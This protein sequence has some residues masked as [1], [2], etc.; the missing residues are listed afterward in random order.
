MGVAIPVM[1]Y[2]GMAAA[3][4]T[5]SPSSHHDLSHA[6]SVSSLSVAGISIVTLMVLGVVL[7]TSFADRRF[8]LQALELE[9]SRR[10]HQIIETALDAF[11]EMDSEGLITNWNARAE[12]TFGWSRSDVIGHPL[13]TIIVPHRYRE[14]HTQ[15]LRRFLTTGEGPVLNKRI[16]ITALRRD[17]SELTL[18]TRPAAVA[19]RL[20]TAGLEA[21]SW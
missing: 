4:F 19:P 10:H 1:H 12:T 14:A 21:R 20:S 5:R 9:S 2:T 15:G 17:G 11:V 6:I 7:L 18:G 8:L 13:A 16:E 3:T